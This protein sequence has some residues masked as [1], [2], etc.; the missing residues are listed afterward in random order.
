VTAAPTS[1]IARTTI[2]IGSVMRQAT[3]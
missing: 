1:Q 3:S 2:I